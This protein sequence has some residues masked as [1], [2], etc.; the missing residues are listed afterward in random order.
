MSIQTSANTESTRDQ[1]TIPPISGAQLS[2]PGAAQS[3][4]AFRGTVSFPLHLVTLAA[5]NGLHIDLSILY[6]SN[7]EWHRRIWN[8]AAPTGLVGLGWSL[9]FDMVI[10]DDGQTGYAG[11]NVYYLVAEGTPVRLHRR[12]AEADCWEFEAEH[13]PFWRVRYHRHREMW[14]VTVEDGDI[15]RFGGT[16]DSLQYAVRWGNWSGSS[17]IAVGQTRIPTVWN[18]SAVASPWGHDIRFEYITFPEDTVAIGAG[19]AAYTRA[20]YLSRITTDVGRGLRFEYGQKSD[21]AQCREFV[22]P[23]GAPDRVDYHA[24]QDRYETRFLQA[25]HAWGNADPARPAPCPLMSLHFDYMLANFSDDPSDPTRCKRYL[26]GVT[27][28]NADG[29]ATPGFLF[30]YYGQTDTPRRPPSAATAGMLKSITYPE[31]KIVTY[32]YEEATLPG[33]SL[34]RRLDETDTGDGVPRV[35]VQEEYVLILRYHQTGR[36][37]T[38]S[39]CSWN[40][41]W[42][43]DRI[44]SETIDG[45]L[46]IDSVRVGFAA[47]CFALGYHADPAAGPRVFCVSVFHRSFGEY[48]RWTHTRLEPLRVSDRKSAAALVVGSRWIAAAVSGE[49]TLR[50]AAWNPLNRGWEDFSLVLPQAADY[51]I[52]ASDTYYVLA[53]YDS[54]TASCLLTLNVFDPTARTWHET[55]LDVVKPIVWT[56]AVPKLHW[57]TSR[58]FAVATFATDMDEDKIRYQVVRY[59]WDEHFRPLRPE[60]LDPK[61]VPRSTP[62]PYYLSPVSGSVVGNLGQVSR[63]NGRGWASARLPLHAD[64]NRPAGLAYGGD[65]A[66]VSTEQG[67]VAYRYDAFA[68]KWQNSGAVGP[69]GQGP[70]LPTI[71][72]RFVTLEDRL[73]YLDEAGRLLERGPLGPDVVAQKVANHGPRFIAY[74]DPRDNTH[75]VYLENGAVFGRPTTIDERLFPDKKGASGTRLTGPDSFVTYRAT[76]FDNA[77]ELTLHKLLRGRVAGEVPHVRVAHLTIDDGFDRHAIA[78]AYEGVATTGAHGQATQYARVR[79]VDGSADPSLRPFGSTLHEYHNGQIQPPVD[80]SYYSLLNGSPRSS[81]VF[82]NAE[83]R[84]SKTDIEWQVFR[85]RETPDGQTVPLYGAFVRHKATT[86]TVFAELISLDDRQSPNR[87]V[88]EKQAELTQR[89]EFTYAAVNGGVRSKTTDN[90]NSRGEVEQVVVETLYGCE[91]Y[92]EMR[93]ANLLSC[94][95]QTTTRVDGDI[96]SRSAVLWTDGA[97]GVDGRPVWAPFRTYHARSA[98]ARLTPAQWTGQSPPPEQDWVCVS[99]V[100]SRNRYGAVIAS[101]TTDGVVD[102][103]LYDKDQWQPVVRCAHGQITGDRAEAAYSGFESYETCEGWAFSDGTGVAESIV[104]G[105]ACTG[106]RSLRI[107]PD[108][109]RALTRTLT[110]SRPRQKFIL[111]G[112]LKTEPDFGAQTGAAQWRLTIAPENAE[113]IGAT[114]P[115]TD[116]NAEWIYF[117]AVLDGS[118]LPA[119]NSGAHQATTITLRATNTKTSAGVL[120][121]HIFF[122]PLPASFA[123]NVYDS[124]TR[125]LTATIAPDAGVEYLIYDRHRQESA[126]IGAG[127]GV[128]TISSAS[129]WREQDRSTSTEIP[130]NTLTVVAARSGGEFERFADGRQWEQRWCD[131]STAWRVVAGRLVHE[132]S[133]GEETITYAPSRALTNFSVYLR[134]HP[135]AASADRPVGIGIGTACRILWSAKTGWRLDLGRTA[136]RIENSGGPGASEWLLLVTSDSIHFYANGRLLFAQP[137]TF[138]LTGPLT[139][140]AADAAAFSDLVVARDCGAEMR[141]CDGDQKTRQTQTLVEGGCIVSAR[142]YDALQRPDITTK[143]SVRPSPNFSFAPSLIT[144][145]DRISG[146]MTGDIADYYRGQDGRSDDQGY[147]YFRTVF[148]PSPLGREIKRGL[149]GREFAIVQATDGVSLVD[150]NPHIT[151]YRYGGNATGAAGLPAAR[152]LVVRHTD[153][154]G[155]ATI[156]WTDQRGQRVLSATGP[157][158]EPGSQAITRHIFDAAGRP[159]ELITPAQ[160]DRQAN[161]VITAGM[162]VNTMAYDFLGRAV[163]RHTVDS[164]L[165]KAI[166]DRSGRRRFDVSSQGLLCRPN[167]VVYTKYDALGRTVEGGIVEVMWDDGEALRSIAESDPNW[168]EPGGGAAYRWIKRFTYDRCNP[169]PAEPYRCDYGLGQLER[170][171]AVN[172]DGRSLVTYDF[173]YDVRG[174][175]VT[176]RATISGEH[177]W[178]SEISY[179]YDGN[180]SLTGMTYPDGFALSYR[181]NRI[182]QVIAVH[183]DQA[184]A[185]IA[186]YHFNADGQ[187]AL[188]RL[189]SGSR[190]VSAVVT[191]LSPGWPERIRFVTDDG[192]LLL[193]ET[194]RYT[195]ARQNGATIPGYYTG[196]IVQVGQRF[197]AWSSAADY[198]Y[199]F[200]TDGQGRLV[201][202]THSSGPDHGVQKIAYDGN[203]NITAMT[204]A[205]QAASYT[206]IPGTN[207]VQHVTGPDGAVVNRIDYDAKGQILSSS[208]RRLDALSYDEA[209][210]VITD[211]AKNHQRRRY[212]YDIDNHRVADIETGANPTATHAAIGPDARRLLDSDGRESRRYIY[213]PDGLLAV[214]TAGRRSVYLTDYQGS[215]RIVMQAGK[216]VAGFNYHPFGALLDTPW[217]DPTTVKAIV[218]RFTGQRYDPDLELY[219]FG[220]R[221]YDPGLARFLGRDPAGQFYS[222][223]L[224]AGNAPHNCIDPD[225]TFV[226]STFL[227]ILA[228]AAVLGG[229]ANAAFHTRETK[230]AGDFFYY[231]GAGAAIGALA[232]IPVAGT[233]ASTAAAA[234]GV[235]AAYAAAYEAGGWTFS[236]TVIG[237]A[238]VDAALTTGSNNLYEGNNFEDGL[239]TSVAMAVGTAAVFEGAAA[240]LSRLGKPKVRGGSEG[241]NHRMAGDF[242]A[243]EPGVPKNA[244]GRTVLSGHG[245]LSN[246]KGTVRVPRGTSVTFY[247]PPGS[248]LS[249]RAGQAVEAGAAFANPRRLRSIVRESGHQIVKR[250]VT[251]VTYRAG[252]RVPNYTLSPISRS[253]LSAADDANFRTVSS[254]RSLRDLLRPGMGKVDWAACTSFSVRG[255]K[256]FRANIEVDWT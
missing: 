115:I 200:K 34:S 46:D 77:R 131:G 185:D 52:A 183:D 173:G 244:A 242:P 155:I 50:R 118:S 121:D 157:I 246:A 158:A 177:P 207:K 137:L 75:I 192:E 148:E 104:E 43:V 211:L 135:L 184:G 103:L 206:Y 111:C 19:G 170:A 116:T 110:P 139:L 186:R 213:G 112:W 13:H 44:L 89:T 119:V 236:G 168:P 145:I 85:S 141:F 57:T 33:S 51:V 127:G 67:T 76:D 80:E 107:A 48:G 28:R 243:Q 188:R 18:Q 53:H 187:L 24:F 144:G 74:A 218:N 6:Q 5:R 109:H 191:H 16:S 190:S 160:A 172:N 231:F 30:D 113:P 84:L 102:S 55:R 133:A 196:R 227:A 59:R 64:A 151:R 216:V 78:Y 209:T 233:A 254:A 124:Q 167:R 38:L 88:S 198:D 65:L 156:V 25:I 176:Q 106:R 180:G 210:G 234:G 66:I 142:L 143:A 195:A 99:E 49:R 4:N 29:E 20:T 97:G 31:G 23:N 179:R 41:A 181:L 182:G 150:R 94:A 68:D 215:T 203:G 153:P 154:D 21:T 204:R 245:S 87:A 146:R 230:S 256:S 62:L 3:V 42:Y 166:Y 98:A 219:D 194:L 7:V 178:R 10:L 152:Y 129:L 61:P 223:Y 248:T 39:V 11:D 36:R 91:V 149:P 17:R 72:D 60:P 255:E 101:R 8:L 45:T 81:S 120:I 175:L 229:A 63:F 164:G 253:W 232:A 122:G 79:V 117:A 47:R 171:A 147:P 128:T 163:E 140:V 12:A 217:G 26:T 108:P 205:G 239:V 240:G 27:A 174:N 70:F 250:G 226:F 193:E 37:L 225:G 14:E 214:D 73:Y 238:A 58:F 221:F 136:N 202:A 249:N 82:D 125:M 237:S 212:L 208:A 90:C 9:G 197:G 224:Y 96:V 93:A 130:L 32:T 40:G 189:S 86:R 100:V 15:K 134:V 138:S 69:G 114:V 22:P 123:A 220:A 247:G 161:G 54:R 241:G 162:P 199:V 235:T 251:P 35:W 95:V 56:E 105:D 1:S 165:T 71:A 201:R 83:T 132:R 159:V 169:D 228:I 126:R 2:G 252:E 222:P 92:P